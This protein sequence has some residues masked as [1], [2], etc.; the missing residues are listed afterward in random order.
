M[1]KIIVTSSS[2]Y[3]GSL[4]C[5]GYALRPSLSISTCAIDF[6]IL[7][8]G[9]S[10]SR[11]LSLFNM[12]K[13]HVSFQFM[14]SA[15]AKY[16]IHPAKG[17]IRPE[18]TVCVHIEF[19]PGEPRNYYKRIFCIVQDQ[20][21]LYCDLVGC[22]YLDKVNF[23][24]LQLSHI[25]EHRKLLND[26]V[27]GYQSA[28]FAGAD[29]CNVQETSND[30]PVNVYESSLDLCPSVSGGSSVECKTSNHTPFIFENSLEQ[31]CTA[32]DIWEEYFLGRTQ[33]FDMVEIAPISLE[34]G[35]IPHLQKSGE[36]G[37]V[38]KNNSKDAILCLWQ[39][40]DISCLQDGDY[41]SMALIVRSKG[42]WTREKPEGN[43]QISPRE[44][45]LS[46]DS[47]MT[48][49]VTF[50]PGKEN[51]FYV[52]TI[53]LCIFHNKH[54]ENHVRA[55]CLASI[56][57]SGNSFNFEQQ[58]FVP[59]AYFFPSR[60]VFPPTLKG[61]RAYQTVSLRNQGCTPLR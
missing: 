13:V 22:C 49:H 14:V 39:N 20:H 52:E 44:A 12:S 16:H 57:V 25:T 26:A 27:H 29:E 8:L 50:A 55:P 3:G 41:T 18:S 40:S 53:D 60:I 48:F 42:P 35:F 59:Q 36:Q 28:S 5:T 54:K 46:P 4:T 7:P 33:H 11:S 58:K 1:G 45:T 31:A 51:Q 15:S 9:S 32:E 61:S 34:F 56:Q 10:I 37:V 23:Q 21:P 24:T 43:F 47:S 17:V 38:V 2:Q 30:L 6:G 19:R